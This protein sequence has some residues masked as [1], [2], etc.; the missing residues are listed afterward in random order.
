MLVV[1]LLC[2]S[3]AG[4]AQAGLNFF[5]AFADAALSV[6]GLGQSGTGGQIQ[7]S[8]PNGATV[9]AAYMYVTTTWN[10][11]PFTDVTLVQGANSV[12]LPAGGGTLLSNANDSSVRRHDVTTFVS[13]NIV[14]GLQNWV[15]NEASSFNSDG[16]VLVVAYRHASTTGATAII[17]DGELA[18]GG[19]TTTLGFAPYAGG[20]VIMS[21]ASE[22]SAGGSQ[23]TNID[24]TT[25]SNSTPRRLTGC[26]GGSDDGVVAN[27][28]LLTVG[29]IGDNASNPAPGCNTSQDD[30]LYDLAQGNSADS[31]PFINN[32]DTSLTFLTNNPSFD[33]NVF[34]IGITAGFRITD[35]D[36]ISTDVPS[37]DAPT[38]D[39]P[40]PTGVP[41]PAPLALL[42]LGLL[43]AGIARIRR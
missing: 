28:A 35:V 37:D 19:D 17:M 23:F 15:V 21:L 30:E 10:F 24:V 3:W 34:F 31:D 9:V 29:G 42:G 12:L 41:A 2:F 22:F 36:D 38:D 20:P 26:A 8:I 43:A 16:T 7:T 32:G 5:N 39:G 40:P 6:D 1:G 33:D 27:G 13:N 25:S 18:L 11:G 4:Q 14:G